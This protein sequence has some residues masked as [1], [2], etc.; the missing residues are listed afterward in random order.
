MKTNLKE[1]IKKTGWA[2]EIETDNLIEQDET[3]EIL[4]YFSYKT[5]AESIILID[6]RD[7]KKYQLSIKKR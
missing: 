7:N 3:N 4:Y 2:L 5:Y 6:S 1:L